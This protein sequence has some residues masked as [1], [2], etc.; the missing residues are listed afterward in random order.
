VLPQLPEVQ[1]EFS[2]TQHLHVVAWSIAELPDDAF[3][4]V[5]TAD[6]CFVVNLICLFMKP[7]LLVLL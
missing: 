5:V 7:H 2:R 1:R 3:V 4:L 6:A